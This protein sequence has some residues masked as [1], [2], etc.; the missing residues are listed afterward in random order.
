MKNN[1][2]HPSFMTRIK[3]LNNKEV[4]LN[5]EYIVYYMQA[6]V[7]TKFNHALECAIAKANQIEKPIIVVFCLQ[8]NFPEA[9]LRSFAFFCW[10]CLVLW[11]T[12]SCMVSKTN[13]WAC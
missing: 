8:E 2:L 9:N 1:F 11:K 4:N 12:R 13:F 7:R 6:S 5:N 3:D 10:H